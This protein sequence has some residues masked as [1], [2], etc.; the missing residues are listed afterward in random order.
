MAIKQP[1]QGGLRFQVR[2]GS[3]LGLVG[4]NGF[5]DRR[6]ERSTGVSGARRAADRRDGGN[7]GGD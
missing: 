4:V 2:R 3:Q 7:G 1:A 5:P 6:R